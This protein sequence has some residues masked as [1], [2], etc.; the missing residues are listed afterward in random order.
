MPFTCSVW[1]F[2]QAFHGTGT[3]LCPLPVVCGTVPKTRH[4]TGP[5]LCPL[6]RVC[7]TVPQARHG[8][9]APLCHG[10]PPQAHCR[11]SPYSP[12]I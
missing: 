7:G 10:T 1:H 8:T 4:G 9:G 3:P 11:T 5:P 6:P 2:S 12:K